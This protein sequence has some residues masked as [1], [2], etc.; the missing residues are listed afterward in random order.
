MDCTKYAVDKFI[1]SSRTACVTAIS[2]S[3]GVKP[4]IFIITTDEGLSNTYDLRQALSIDYT[5]N[6]STA[7]AFYNSTTDSYG[8]SHVLLVK[9]HL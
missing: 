2:R 3:L 7:Y 5:G 4:E 1:F 8:T 6:P 9:Q